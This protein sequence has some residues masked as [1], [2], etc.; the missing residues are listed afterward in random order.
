M[1]EWCLLGAFVRMLIS[2]SIYC[3]FCTVLN[4]YKCIIAAPVSFRF[5]YFFVAYFSLCCSFSLVLLP[6]NYK[7]WTRNMSTIFIVWQS[8]RTNPYMYARYARFCARRYV[9][10]QYRLE[11]SLCVCA[12][13]SVFIYFCQKHFPFCWHNSTK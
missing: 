1:I 13:M 10:E 8:H 2:F 5:Y 6:F 9:Y 7:N 11:Y 12:C 3:L 4:S